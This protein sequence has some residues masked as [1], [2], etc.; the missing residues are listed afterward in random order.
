MFLPYLQFQS[1]QVARHQALDLADGK[2]D[3]VQCS[4]ANNL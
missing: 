4:A 1:E 3:T 2:P